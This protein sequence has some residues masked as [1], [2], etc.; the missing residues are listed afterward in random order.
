MLISPKP[1]EILNQNQLHL[2][3]IDLSFILEPFLADFSASEM[4]LFSNKGPPF[5]SSKIDHYRQTGT[6]S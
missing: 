4:L 3:R 1:L 2:D 5:E 6:G